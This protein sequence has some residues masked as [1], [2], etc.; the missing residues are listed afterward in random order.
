MA[1]KQAPVH[2]YSSQI[3]AP[4]MQHVFMSLAFGLTFLSGLKEKIV[5]C[6]EDTLPTV[7]GGPEAKL[8][9]PVKT[10]PPNKSYS[11]ALEIFISLQ[12]RTYTQS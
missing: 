3:E 7:C 6:Y 10:E 4:K 8:P 11:R 2:N 1:C 9:P 12:G 5:V